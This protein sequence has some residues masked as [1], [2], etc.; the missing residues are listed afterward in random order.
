M[1]LNS[2]RWYIEGDCR[3][4]DRRVQKCGVSPVIDIEV[5]D[6]NIIISDNGQ[7]IAAETVKKILDYT[8]RA[9]DV[10]SLTEVKP[11]CDLLSSWRRRSI[12]LG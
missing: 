4:R 10:A 3:Q 11:V 12:S 2:G 8:V 1:V 5:A 9:S 7:G 6:G